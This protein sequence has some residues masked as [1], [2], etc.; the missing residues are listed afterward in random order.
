MTAI[1]SAAATAAFPENHVSPRLSPVL[2]ELLQNE[3]QDT[4]P[5]TTQYIRT[6]INVDE[7]PIEFWTEELSQRF[8]ISRF[9]TVIDV[10]WHAPSHRV[11]VRIVNNESMG[12]FDDEHYFLTS[13]DRTRITL[14]DV[15]Y[16]LYLSQERI[17]L[18]YSEDHWNLNSTLDTNI[19]DV[20]LSQFTIYPVEAAAP[21]LAPSPTPT[22][23][24][25]M[26][27]ENNVLIRQ[28]ANYF[29]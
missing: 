3:L 19:E 15:L 7:K 20:P 5:I 9:Q 11:F 25:D 28:H 10:E 6:H 12:R 26:S 24:V 22:E 27:Y 29:C 18:D 13:P 16:S 8:Q 2:L 23:V 1:L 4:T 21:A 17:V 14:R